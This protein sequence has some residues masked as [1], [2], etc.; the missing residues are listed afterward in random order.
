M[1]YNTLIDIIV[2]TWNNPEVIKRLV[3]SLEKNSNLKNST[4]IYVHVQENNQKTTEFL[5]S[6]NIQ[7]SVSSTNI[8][9]C[10][11]LNMAAKL[12]KGQYICII[13]D[14]M[15]VG[16][17]WDSELIGFKNNNKL[18][19]SDLLCSVSVESQGA[20]PLALLRDYG[21]FLDFNETGFNNDIEVLKKQ[22]PILC[23]HGS[24]PLLIN[25]TFWEKIEGYDERFNPSP[26]AE[27][28]IAM[29]AWIQGCRNFIQVPTSI[30]YHFQSMSTNR[31]AGHN[32]AERRE[33][34]FS[35]SYNITVSEFV[36]MYIKR[37]EVWEKR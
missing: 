6:K 25:R 34:I 9:M 17:D 37:G 35:E 4:S 12:G 8:G 23:N 22:K 11:G 20:N 3:L 16:K 30:V 31:I 24:V 15:Y 21:S 18:I 13:D 29:K 27:E 10:S 26:G 14:D 5:K 7:F 32:Y 19:E 28:G 33:K 1:Y 36:K 2:S